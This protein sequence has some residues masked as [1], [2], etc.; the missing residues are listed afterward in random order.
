[1][2][3]EGAHFLPRGHIPQARAA[4]PECPGDKCFAVGGKIEGLDRERMCLPAA[5]LRALIRVPQ[6]DRP[7]AVARGQYPAVAG[8]NQSSHLLM[9]AV[10]DMLFLVGRNVPQTNGLIR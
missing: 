10:E 4:L 8:K 2:S 3:S 5:D 6:G 9:I 1:M 7:I